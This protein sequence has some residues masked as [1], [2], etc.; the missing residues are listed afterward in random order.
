MDLVRVTFDFKDMVLLDHLN[1][2]AFPDD[3]RVELADLIA[4]SLENGREMLAFYEVDT[5]I[6]FAVLMSSDD[7]VYMSFFAVQSEL[8][9]NGYGSRVLDAI[10]SRYPH[11]SFCLEVERLDEDCV[12][13]G[14]RLARWRFY[15]RNNFTETGYLLEYGKL[16]FDILCRGPFKPA[17][18]ER[19]LS[20]IATFRFQVRRR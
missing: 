9:G 10:S 2:E 16:S 12:N 20:S 5:F 17:S 14:E 7:L 19:L 15:E 13:R 8:R 18:Y 6:G 1:K 3:E 4:Y 11:R